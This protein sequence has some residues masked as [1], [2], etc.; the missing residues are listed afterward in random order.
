M[1][2]QKAPKNPVPAKRRNMI[3]IAAHF[4]TSAGPF[5]RRPRP[6]HEKHAWKKEHWAD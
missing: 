5:R 2:R 3:A 6:D 1:T 4:R